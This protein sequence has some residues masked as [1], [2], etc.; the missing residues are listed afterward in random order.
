MTLLYFVLFVVLSSHRRSPDTLQE[1][2]DP[3]R[4]CLGR[5]EEASQEGR[6][7]SV[8]RTPPGCASGPGVWSC[9]G[10]GPLVGE[11]APLVR[12]T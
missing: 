8:H 10:Q 6:E 12:E 9:P 4:S 1:G 11:K 7:I 2:R 5:K 3:E